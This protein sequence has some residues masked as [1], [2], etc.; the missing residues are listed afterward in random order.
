MCSEPGWKVGPGEV[1]GLPTGAFVAGDRALGLIN[2]E[3]VPLARIPTGT[4]EV[5]KK[6][7]VRLWAT[8]KPADSGD[9]PA[10][11]DKGADLRKRLGL[12]DPTDGAN[13]S[14]AKVD[15][16]EV[17]TLEVT[18]D[19]QDVRYK[20][21]RD[22]C[23]LSSVESFSD[24]TLEGP[25]TTLDLSKHMQRFGGDPANWMLQ[26]AREKHIIARR[27]QAIADAHTVAG[28]VDWANGKFFSGTG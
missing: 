23:A 27:I 16:E 21:W 3:H 1:T 15:D 7:M 10:D 9:P 14:A 25:I 19:E 24:F 2:G 12:A 20:S 22:A 17:R 11:A 4:A 18:W 5:F 26:F 28:K 13:K 8:L 6:E